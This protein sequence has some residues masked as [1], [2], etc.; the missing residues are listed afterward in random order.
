[1]ALDKKALGVTLGVLWGLC[2]LLCTFWVMWRGGGEHLYLLKQ[3]YPGYGVNVGGAFLG[4]V[5]GFADGFVGG[6]VFGW[7]YNKLAKK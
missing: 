4:L 3:F 6:W 7:L 2:V 5:Y 1:M